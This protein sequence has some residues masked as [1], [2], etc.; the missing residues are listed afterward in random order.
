M[1]TNKRV[2]LHMATHRVQQALP[3]STL[4]R[5]KCDIH[6]E[7]LKRDSAHSFPAQQ[8]IFWLMW[9]RP[10]KERLLDLQDCMSFVAHIHVLLFV[11]YYSFN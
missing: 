8:S 2:C 5:H 4:S 3:M 6:P 9:K 10:Y 1:Y 11:F 7:L